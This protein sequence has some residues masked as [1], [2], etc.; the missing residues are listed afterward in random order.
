MKDRVPD[1]TGLS[2][3]TLLPLLGRRD[4]NVVI[5]GSGWVYRQTPPPGAAVKPG[6]TLTLEL[7]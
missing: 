3:R 4:V 5:T 6:M 1:F 7:R 2:K